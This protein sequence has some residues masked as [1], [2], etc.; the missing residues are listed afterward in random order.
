MYKSIDCLARIAYIH[1]LNII[2]QISCFHMYYD[3]ILGAM[4]CFV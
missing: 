3:L 4:I 2:V 1:S